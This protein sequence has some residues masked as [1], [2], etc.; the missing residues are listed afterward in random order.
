MFNKVEQIEKI[1]KEIMKNN[2]VEDW[3]GFKQDELVSIYNILENDN[4]SIANNY[5]VKSIK[6]S[7]KEQLEKIMEVLEDISNEKKEFLA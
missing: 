1:M 6:V 4:K 7:S 2:G 5:Q 3:K